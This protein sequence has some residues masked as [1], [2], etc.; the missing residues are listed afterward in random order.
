M[1]TNG[2]IRRLDNVGRL[3]IPKEIRKKHD[4]YEGDLVTI[5]DGISY[6][7][8]KKYRNGCIFCGSEEDIIEYKGICVC[9][10]CRK[11]LNKELIQDK[12]E[13]KY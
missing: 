8:I 3:V 13:L 6:V 12:N 5:I 9:K 4:I 10:N 11:S 2:I 1:I 7:I